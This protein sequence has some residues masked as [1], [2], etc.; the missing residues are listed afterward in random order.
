LRQVGDG[1]RHDDVERAAGERIL[2][3]GGDHRDA[4][5]STAYPGHTAATA[6]WPHYARRRV[7]WFG[8]A[9]EQKPIELILA[10]SLLDSLSTP[11][12]LIDLEGTLVYYNEAVARL[13]G[14]SFE[15]TGPMAATE[16]SE[17]FGPFDAEGRRIPFE[18]HPL[19]VAVRA[20]RAGH[21]VQC[22]RAAGGEDF[23]VA[24]SA[25]PLVG[26]T[27]FEGALVF[28]WPEPRP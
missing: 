11:G 8:I 18:D 24:V 27:G 26:T 6:R 1:R 16:W 25:I 10:R 22:F 3:P 21:Y 23:E 7:R 5:P 2:R 9:A 14:M 17:A 28:F 12:C 15:E 13:A 19:T 4:G 20:G